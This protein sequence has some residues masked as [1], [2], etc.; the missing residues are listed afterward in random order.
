MLAA[1]VGLQGFT[2]GDADLLGSHRM[3]LQAARI[4]GLFMVVWFLPN[5]QQVMARFAP[6]ISVNT[7]SPG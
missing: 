7:A 1:A 2:L 4:A 5:T 3:D 6:T